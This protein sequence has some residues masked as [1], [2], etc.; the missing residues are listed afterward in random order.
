MAYI[1]TRTGSTGT[2]WRVRWRD[3]LGQQRV[4]P[5]T[6]EDSANKWL[7]LFNA[8]GPARALAYLDDEAPKQ[9]T[10]TVAWV[11]HHIDHLTGITTGTRATY[12]RY[13]EL[14]IRPHFKDT[15]LDMLDEDEI[16]RWVIWMH[17]TRGHAGKTIRNRH[18]L[19]SDAL[20]KASRAGK[21][22][23]NP[24]EGT[25]LPRTPEVD[26]VYLTADEFQRFIA[27][28][29]PFYQPF[30]LSLAGTGM[31]FGELTALQ[32]RNVNFADSTIN[33][34]Q[35]WK[36]TDRGA[37][38]ELG[39]PKT[40]R[41]RRTITA[42]P[43]VMTA[44]A[45]V[46]AGRRPEELVFLN[47]A[48][49]HIKA[50]TFYRNVWHPARAAFAGDQVERVKDPKTGRWKLTTLEVGPGKRPRVHDLRHTNAAWSLQA[51]VS[52]P[53]LQ[54][55]LGHES[56]QTTV[57]VYGH[58]ARENA[59]QVAAATARNLPDLT[60]LAGEHLRAVS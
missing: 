47:A 40:R 38:R 16:A 31:R 42:P 24:C 1:E 17:E 44:I 19:L 55:H 57:D 4:V 37:Q 33:V 25:R 36:T 27:R 18:S 34:S 60:A 29:Q 15:T 22:I 30:V 10:D 28:V 12:R 52:L 56:I 26:H 51:G 53:A 21:M 39:V 32:I 50:P 45:A 23:S 46:T 54:R 3:E 5:F 6:D 35:A 20:H 58:L 7:A 2:R 41:A 8:V 11:V 9:T 14:D 43:H 49:D 59:D 13:V 48:G